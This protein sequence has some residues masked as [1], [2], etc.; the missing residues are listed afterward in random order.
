M[1]SLR[2]FL[3]LLVPIAGFAWLS[4]SSGDDTAPAQDFT[5]Y[6]HLH[7]SLSGRYVQQ[8]TAPPGGVAILSQCKKD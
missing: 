2:A 6:V 7:E 8:R 3:L 4:V 1:T 5:E